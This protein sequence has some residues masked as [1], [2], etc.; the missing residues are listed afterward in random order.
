MHLQEVVLGD[1][2]FDRVHETQ[3]ELMIAHWKDICV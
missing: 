1:F 3:I 2:I